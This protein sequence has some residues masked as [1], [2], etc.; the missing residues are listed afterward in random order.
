MKAISLVFILL[1]AFLCLSGFHLA[2]SGLTEGIDRP[3]C[4]TLFVT[5]PTYVVS[6]NSPITFS[7]DVSGGGKKGLKDNEVIVEF[8]GIQSKW[9][10]SYKW[11]VS[12]GIIVG[13]QGARTVQIEPTALKQSDAVNVL[14]T[15]EVGGMDPA[16][17]RTSSCS[18]K[19]DP[20]CKTP[21]K[22]SEYG[23]LSFEVE[24]EQ[25]DNFATYL[26]GGGPDSVAYILAYGGRKSCFWE[27][28]KLRVERAKNY[29]VEHY[30]IESDRIV[31]FDGG[32]RKNLT[33]ELFLSS[34]TGCGPFPTPTIRGSMSEIKG[35]CLE[36]Y[37]RRNE[38]IKP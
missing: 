29:L 18:L 19:V 35:S 33:V 15:V 26:L 17:S 30:S 1:L 20:G 7:L 9:D 27:E 10:L 16:C 4:P 36:K 11:D 5:C 25:L 13:G 22:F 31:A 2:P 37:K 28:G 6:G 34:R 38:P 24:K 3:P 8:K 23:D 12:G 21:E 14:A 32:Y